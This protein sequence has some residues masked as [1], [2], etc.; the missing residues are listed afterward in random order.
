MNEHAMRDAYERALRARGE[1]ASSAD[2]PLERLE[3]L[4]AREGS[5]ADRLR[6]LDVALSSVEGRR[7]LDVLWSAARAARP[8][9]RPWMSP[10]V[11]AMAAA[12][13]LSVGVGGWW[14]RTTSTDVTRTGALP[15]TETS[16]TMRG[17]ASP[18]QLVA[19]H[20]DAISTRGAHFVWHRVAQAR[21][22]TLV[23]VDRAGNE[24]FAS[25]TT[26]TAVTLPDSVR[27]VAGSEYLW[28]VQA[29]MPDGNT[30][31]AVTEK[32]RVR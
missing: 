22:Y 18:V 32:I 7:E 13:V 12:V 5:E 20:G 25:T 19:P 21:V 26:D 10:R 1:S 9:R 24:V 30:V 6:A 23:V 15:R 2:L 8:V 29:V 31:S 27:L 16:E 28:W 17:E 11:T 3:A 14:I 4:V